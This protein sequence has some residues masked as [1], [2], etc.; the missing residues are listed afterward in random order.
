M[1]E[2]RE[3]RCSLLNYPSY[4]CQKALPSALFKVCGGY[5]GRVTPVPIPNTEVKPA[6]ADG[7]ARVTVWESRSLPHFFE[8]RQRKRWRASP[9]SGARIP[10]ASARR[11]EGPRAASRG[12]LSH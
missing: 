11:I 10:L 6:R 12:I 3:T 2:S 9:F 7:T 4:G 5:I 1:F 8:A